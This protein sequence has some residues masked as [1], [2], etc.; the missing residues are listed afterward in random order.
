MLVLGHGL[1][2]AALLARV[3]HLVPPTR[4][5][6]TDDV[7]VRGHE[8]GSHLIAGDRWYERGG[9]LVYGSPSRDPW[10][11]PG[12]ADTRSNVLEEVARWGLVAIT[13]AAGPVVAVDLR[14]GEWQAALNCMAA[15][16]RH[17][18]DHQLESTT[19]GTRHIPGPCRIIADT[20]PGF[21]YARLAEEIDQHL[22]DTRPGP[23][24]RDPTDVRSTRIG[25]VD[26]SV[27]TSRH[28]DRALV[29]RPSNL[30]D[31][32][33]DPELFELARSQVVPCLT[34]RAWRLGFDLH[35]PFLE[36]PVLDQLGYGL[37]AT[38]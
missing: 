7:R 26:W 4:G 32:L 8:W 14:T 27:T 6:G 35:A 19:A 23:Q 37:G 34:W 33:S 25:S 20:S 12:N 21:R 22:P 11:A 13:M 15:L 36:R 17:E 18:D 2:P 9:L 5:P 1:A 16:G 3:A 30:V 10:G 28:G 29:L 31:V 24:L 38:A